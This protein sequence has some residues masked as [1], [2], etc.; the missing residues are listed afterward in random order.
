M[1]TL[2]FLIL[3]TIIGAVLAQT[4][5]VRPNSCGTCVQVSGCC[6][7]SNPVGGMCFSKQMAASNCANTCAKPD[8]A[9]T[10]NDPNPPF[11]PPDFPTKIDINIEV[12]TTMVVSYQ[13]AILFRILGALFVLGYLAVAALVIFGWVKA[14]P[15]LEEMERYE[16]NPAPATLRDAIPPQMFEILTNSISYEENQQLNWVGCQAAAVNRKRTIMIVLL[17]FGPLLGSV[18][19]IATIALVPRVFSI[20]TFMSVI[21]FGAITGFTYLFV[22]KVGTS[23]QLYAMTPTHAIIIY[24]RFFGRQE[25]YRYRY[26]SPAY[27]MSNPTSNFGV[28]SRGTLIFADEF[29][30]ETVHHHHKG[31][32][33]SSKE[34]KVKKIGFV[35]VPRYNTC[36]SVF[37]QLRDAARSANPIQFEETY[38]KSDILGLVQ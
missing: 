7:I 15:A 38:S 33:H 30:R 3:F 31:R 10:F 11:S 19:A 16:N 29:V 28:G 1:K 35:D 36:Q 22:K 27:M 34:W 5:C 25:V 8:P 6:W 13:V 37:F 18:A 14:Q 26:D 20:I 9:S 32:V 4:Q 21:F 24:Q 2:S 12:H 17:C 23:E